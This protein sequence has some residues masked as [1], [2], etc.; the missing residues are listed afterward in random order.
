MRLEDAPSPRHGL[1][2]VGDTLRYLVARAAYKLRTY[3][4][5]ASV[6][7]PFSSS[8]RRPCGATTPVWAGNAGHETDREPNDR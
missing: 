2:G 5:R 6:G 3:G 7:D 4:Q 8:K 1:P